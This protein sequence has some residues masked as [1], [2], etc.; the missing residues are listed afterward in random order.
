MKRPEPRDC[1]KGDFQSTRPVDAPPRWIRIEPPDE[2]RDEGL[3][4]PL[5]LGQEVGLAQCDKMTVPIEFPGDLFIASHR[6][7]EIVDTTPMIGP[8]PFARGWLE[9][10]V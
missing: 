5:I 4:I 10:P 1:Q 8:R 9:M 2:L 7:V 6:R 3:R